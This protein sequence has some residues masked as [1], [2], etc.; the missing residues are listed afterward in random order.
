MTT[1]S[2]GMYVTSQT[3]KIISVVLLEH[4]P[5]ASGV[6]VLLWDNVMRKRWDV[7]S[8]WHVPGPAFMTSSTALEIVVELNDVSD[9]CD[10]NISAMAVLKPPKGELELRNLSAT[11]G[12]V[13]IGLIDKSVFFVFLFCFVFVFV[14]GWFFF[15]GE[16]GGGGGGSLGRKL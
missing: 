6:F 2:C 4:S 8:T 16:V 14:F 1:S 10:F 9:P 13:S 5:C 11:E 12:K 3:G 7:C 15:R